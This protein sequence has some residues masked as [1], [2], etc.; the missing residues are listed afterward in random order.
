MKFSIIFL[1]IFIYQTVTG[2]IEF[3]AELENP[4][5]NELNKVNPHACFIPY[6]DK[7]SAERLDGEK[8]PLYLSLNGTWKF[9]W[10]ENPAFRP[11]NFYEP[12]YDDSG[13]GTIPVP[14]NWER[15]GYG[16]PIYVNMDYEWTYEP[17][18]PYVPHDFNPVGSY[19]KTFQIPDHWSGKQVYIHYGAVK[20]AFF[21]WINGTKVGYSEDSK[22]PAEWNITP[23]LK[24]GENLIALEVYRWSDGSFLECQDFWRISGIE[25]DVYLYATTEVHISDFFARTG[26]SKDYNDGLLDL[27]VFVENLSSIEKRPMRTVE[28]IL[29]DESGKIVLNAT[30]TA[31]FNN[32]STTG[33]HLS[34][35][36]PNV[37]SWSAETPALYQLIILLKDKESIVTEAIRQNIGFRSSVIKNGQ[38]LVNGKPVLLKGV[39]RH[40]HDPVT[41]HVISKE[42]MLRDIT[43]MKQHNINT[44]R[45]CHYPDDPYWYDLCDKYGLYV[46]DEANIESHGMGYGDESLAKDTVWKD[47][48]VYRVKNM[49]ERDKNHASVIIWSMGNEAGDGINF[50]ACYEWIKQRDPYRPIHYERALLGPNTDIYC[51]MYASIEYLEKYASEKQTRP[52]ILC[53]YSHSMGNSTGNLQDYWDVIEKYDHLQGACIWDWV[54]QGFFKRDPDGKEYYAYGGDFGPPDVPSDGNFCCNGLV[55]ADRTPHPALSEV[56][57]VYQNIKVHLLDA[58]RGT[59][60]IDNG[61]FFQNL[62]FVDLKWEV[63]ANGIVTGSGTSTLP[64]VLPQQSVSLTLPILGLIQDQSQEY[65]LNVSFI[66]NKEKNLVPAEFTIASEQIKL[67]GNRTTSQIV[68]DNLSSLKVAENETLLSILGNNFRITFDKDFGRI[69]SYRYDEEELMKEGPQINFWRAPTDNDFG[70]G[71]ES[72]CAIWKE[73]SKQQPPQKVSVLK[74]AND[75]V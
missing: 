45:T 21:I 58:A 68:S 44:V 41:G 4:R 69:K 15:N 49:L 36:I 10:V 67:P 8:S 20:S 2:Q 72:R 37:K 6:P 5:I 51:P 22:T 53:E 66:T 61:Y 9:N 73:A 18:P 70:N 24:N 30:A 38:L 23:F 55:S 59:L 3:P 33:V 57:K 16:Y 12:D 29:T 56:K 34:G 74:A 50:T 1:L 27:S 17:K 40:E 14:A 35:I 32:T 39:N 25:R 7:E 46:I 52:L 71:M 65:F 64:E 43:L 48:H 42:S 47:A 11:A 62:G 28:A 75:E 60:R 19:R 54:D 13:W 31:E 63:T 26:L